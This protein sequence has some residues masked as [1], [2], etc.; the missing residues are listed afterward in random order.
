MQNSALIEP[1]DSDLCLK[2]SDKLFLCHTRKELE[3][4]LF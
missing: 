4:G 1:S 3:N 2:K